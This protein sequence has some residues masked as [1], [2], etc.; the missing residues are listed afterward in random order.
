MDSL[1]RMLGKS[2]EKV[3]TDDV[4]PLHMLDDT[5]TL[6]G[7]V[8]TWTL[9]FNDV[10]D[11]DTLHSSLSRLLEI[12]DWRKLGGRLRLND[13]GALEIHVPTPF[14]PDRPAVAYSYEKLSVDIDGHELGC[15][16]PKVTDKLSTHPGPENFKAFAT[17]PDAPQAL[18][19]FIYHD[20]PLL[21]LHVTA[22]NDA[23]LVGLS[24]PH[25]LMDVMG[26]QALLRAWSSVLAGREADVPPVLGARED[27]FQTAVSTPGS[28]EKFNMGEKQ[29]KG[30]GL[31]QFGLRYAWD[32]MTGPA[33]ES[34]MIYLPATV[35]AALRRQVEADLDKSSGDMPFLSDNDILT[36]WAAQVVGMSQQQPRP[37][38]ALY[39]INARFRITSLSQADGVFVQ[40][41]AVAG[42]TMLSP[43]ESTGALGPIALANRQQLHT[44]AT[45]H[46]VNAFVR[47]LQGDAAGGDPRILCGPSDAVLMPLTNWER[48][49]IFGS[50]D[51]GAAVTRAGNNNIPGHI[52][53]HHPS[54]MGTATHK[55]LFVVLGKD[56]KGGYWLNSHLTPRGW[57]L[58]ADTLTTT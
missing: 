42:F 37:V 2:P 40:N 4:Y 33:A 16:L 11:A 32:L 44:Q 27:V 20:V 5:K 43:S 39:V 34:K 36:A 24:W 53:Y 26:Q 51:F 57:E 10:M 3:E 31:I 12:G 46:Q 35:I 9:R 47:A 54:S 25:V 55:N 48:A 6:R 50:V 22:F 58:V 28:D 1:W 19:D 52:T 15:Q 8:V 13:Q 56:G 29:L 17:R 30:A 21:S 41:M 49:D 38:T 45:E 14:T 7:I 23:T 18:N